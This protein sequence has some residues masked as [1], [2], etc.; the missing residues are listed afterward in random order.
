MITL[1]TDLRD[2]DCY[3]GT[4]MIPFDYKL[5]TENV[6]YKLMSTNPNDMAKGLSYTAADEEDTETV[7]E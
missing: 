6:L 4:V 7:T 5:P 3:N 1:R 2:R